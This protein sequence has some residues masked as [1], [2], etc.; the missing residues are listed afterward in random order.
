MS[1]DETARSTS[2]HLLKSLASAQAGSIGFASLTLSIK[3][4]IERSSAT[5]TLGSDSRCDR[6]GVTM[7]LHG[8]GS[9]KECLLLFVHC[10]QTK[11]EVL[12][13]RRYSMVGSEKISD[14]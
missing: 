10:F 5:D 9:S 2:R 12:T 11:R 7:V 1:V 4:S 14:S 8:M 6:D 13:V 3:I